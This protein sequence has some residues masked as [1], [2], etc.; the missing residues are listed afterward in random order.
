MKFN[1]EKKKDNAS[2]IEDRMY[3]KIVF[4]II[5]QG[6]NSPEKSIIS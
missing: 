5:D 4:H 1:A 3:C 6:F 2:K